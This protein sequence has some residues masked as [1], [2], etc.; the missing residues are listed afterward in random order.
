MTTLATAKTDLSILVGNSTK[1]FFTDA[2]LTSYIREAL[3]T[4]GAAS[5]FYRK[6]DT[7]SSVANQPFYDLPSLVSSLAYSTTDKSI[8]SDLEYALLEPQSTDFLSWS[9]TE[10]FSVSSLQQAIQR[11]RDQFLLATMMVLTNQ[12]ILTASPPISR[13]SLPTDLLD[14]QRVASKSISGNYRILQE[15]DEFSLGAYSPSWN[16]ASVTT[17]Q[18]PD[19]YSEILEALLTIQL[20]P[21]ATDI[22]SLDLL[23]I[24]VGPILDLTSASA[25]AVKLGVPEA[26]TWVIKYGALYE[27]LGPHTQNHDPIRAQYC[28][29]RWEEGIQLAKLY[30]S[31]L[32]AEIN[33]VQANISTLAELDQYTWNWMNTRSSTPNTIA[34]ASWNL[35]ALSP[36]PNDTT[37]SIVIDYLCNPI[38]PVIDADILQID[39]AYYPIILDYARHIAMFKKGGQEFSQSQ[40]GYD[41]LVQAASFHNARLRAQSLYFSSLTDNVSKQQ[42]EKPRVDTAA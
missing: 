23:Y 18:Q 32:N 3:L 13:V 21:I 41:R 42:E 22:T 25:T 28:K 37:A 19:Y 36:V 38:L 11:A 29:L 39:Q 26:F 30:S 1:T 33:G 6:R 4:W 12:E 35:L 24:A 16:L 10:Q 8:A 20:A 9:G 7:F 31:V 17:L 34:V 14:L 2:E 5:L 40:Q 15:E 27:L